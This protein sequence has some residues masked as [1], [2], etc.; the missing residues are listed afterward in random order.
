MPTVL[1]AGSGGLKQELLTAKTLFNP[2]KI[3]Y[4]GNNFEMWQ[5]KRSKN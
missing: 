1:E 2:R 4:S 5:P 3:F